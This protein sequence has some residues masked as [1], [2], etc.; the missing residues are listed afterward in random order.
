M[1]SDVPKIFPGPPLETCVLF[2][3]AFFLV[4]GL[5]FLK[6]ILGESHVLELAYSSLDG[7]NLLHGIC[8]GEQSSGKLFLCF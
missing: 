4:C 7:S 2:L 1:D 3:C 5:V 6:G 8:S